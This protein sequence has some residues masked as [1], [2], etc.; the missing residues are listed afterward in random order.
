[1]DFQA[2]GADFLAFS[3]HKMLGPT[4][5]GALIAKR[6]HLEAMPPFFGGGE[7]IREVTLQRSTW[8]D[9]PAKFEAGTMNFADA[10]GLGAAIDYLAPLGM[11]MVHAHGRDLAYQAMRAL[12]AIP[13][14]TVYGPPVTEDRG[15]VVSFLVDDIHAHDVAG[16]LDRE[17]IAVRAGHHCAMPLHARL[18]VPATARASFTVYNDA[19]EI[20]RLAEGIKKVKAVFHR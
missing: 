13:G 8:A 7:M 2:T 19:S 15:A 9:V 4:G 18:G 17:G 1:M 14:V 10:V 16:V 5:I 3:G 12:Q 20:D 6:E 11:D